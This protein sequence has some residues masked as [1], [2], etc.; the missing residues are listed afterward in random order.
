MWEWWTYTL[1]DFLPFSP[2][3]YYRLLELHNR[4]LW[5]A[6]ILTSGL[7]LAVLYLLLWPVRGRDS[8]IPAILGGLWMWIAWAFLWRRYATINWASAH[9]APFF[10]LQGLL[11][12]WSGTIR[13]RLVFAQSRDI[14]DFIA[15]A[16]FALSLLAYPFLAPLLGRP[17]FAAELF[18]IAP[19]PTAVA[20]LAALALAHGRTKSLL[21]LVPLLWCAVSGMTLWT[22]DADDFFI[23]P[24]GALTALGVAIAH[25]RR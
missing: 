6:Q 23:A 14:G 7:G 19:D 2:R 15:L 18:G 1:S 24:L 8:L 3:V 4:A 22:L 13:R 10:A 21:L 11:L 17:W 5:P 9:I 12:I 25:E 16:L 20:T